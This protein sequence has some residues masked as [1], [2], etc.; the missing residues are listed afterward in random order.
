M[1]RLAVRTRQPGE[2]SLQSGYPAQ[3]LFRR[4]LQHDSAGARRVGFVRLPRGVFPRDL[5]YLLV[6]G[7]TAVLAPGQRRI[8]S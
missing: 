5:W 1:V 6:S 4:Y 7:E 8:D 2:Q 3:F